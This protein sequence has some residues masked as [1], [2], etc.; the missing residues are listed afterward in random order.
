MAKANSHL[1]A[2]RS[3]HRRHLKRVCK[4]VVNEDATRQREHLRL[5]LQTA[6]W[7]REDKTVI[8][9]L[10]VGASMMTIVM[11][12]LHAEALIADKFAPIHNLIIFHIHI[13]CGASEWS[14]HGRGNAT[15]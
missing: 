11:I 3:P 15:P 5:I 4:T 8:I 12:S 6:E 9:S 13:F 7:G 10:K 2:Q 1:M 14:L